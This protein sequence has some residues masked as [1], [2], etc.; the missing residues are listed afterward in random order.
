MLMSGQA[1]VCNFD[2]RDAVD[3]KVR[4]SLLRSLETEREAARWSRGQDS[5]SSNRIFCGLEESDRPIERDGFELNWDGRLDNREEVAC[6]VDPGPITSACDQELVLALYQQFG[7]SSF[8]MLLGD[9]TLALWDPVRFCLVLARDP[10]GVHRLFYRIDPRG[11]AWCS[12]LEPLLKTAQRKLHLD[13]DYL[14]GCLYPRPPLESTPFREI[15]SLP[16]GSFLTCHLGGKIQIETFWRLAP[17]SSIRYADDRD[18]EEHFRDLLCKAVSR[19]LRTNGTVMAE[20]SGGI[21]SSSLVCVADLVSEREHLSRVETISYFDDRDVGGDERPFFNLIE[22]HR[23]RDGHHLRVSSIVADNF[24]IRYAETSNLCAFPGRTPE[25][26]ALS[27]A[28]LAVYRNADAKV[29]L[30]GLGGDEL[31]GGISWEAPELAGYLKARQFKSFFHAVVEWSLRRNKSIYALGWDAVELLLCSHWPGLLMERP[32]R[33]SWALVGPPSSNGLNSF[34][35]WDELAPSQV[36]MESVRYALAQQ[37]TWIDTPR[38]ECIER[39]FP[40]L[41]R[42]LFTFL[43]SIP[44]M[45][46]V[47][48]GKR[49]DLMRRAL[50]GIVPASILFRKTKWLGSHLTNRSLLGAIDSATE[51]L[52]GT[53]LSENLLVDSSALRDRLKLAEHGALAEQRAA[54]TALLIEQWLRGPVGAFISM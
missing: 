22:Q 19:R 16:P 52:S 29:V 33:Y 37:L 32:K 14:S 17:E 50:R 47:R 36:A 42:D 28:A 23:G 31:L 10:M 13:L 30:S 46:I 24:D 26:A 54:H 8:K 49:R 27:N 51:H 39:R 3:A 45:Q 7:F 34:A 25:S 44:R 40:Y 41:D 48:A 4:V 5:D 43:A 15:R 6:R 53:W 20:L 35:R 38:G 18:Y 1:G 2:A 21:D 12:T 9:W 11:L